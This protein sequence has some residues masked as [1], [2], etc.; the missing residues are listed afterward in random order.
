MWPFSHP[1]AQFSLP[2]DLLYN[3]ERWADDIPITEIAIMSD[4][5]FGALIHQNARLGSFAVAAARQ[6]PS[7]S[8]SAS[9]QP[10]A[11]DLLRVR[12]ELRKAFEWSEKQHGSLE[13]FWVWVEDDENLSILQLA[14][15]LVRPH[16]TSIHLAF[17]IPVAK[18]P[19]SLCVRA[20]SDRWIGAEEEHFVDLDGL[21]L[22]PVAPP[23]VPLLDLPLV[24]TGDALAKQ[25]HLRD[26][27][28]QET[29]ALDPAQTQAFHTVFHSSS[30]VL[31]CS[32][33]APSRGT[34]LELAMWCVPLTSPSC[35]SMADVGAFAG[36][37]SGSS[38][39]P[40][41]S[42]S[43]RARPS[44]ARSPSASSRPS[45]APR[46]SPSTSSRATPT[47]TASSRPRPPSASRRRTRS[48]AAS[49]ASPRLSR[50]STSSSR[51]TC[52]RSTRRTSSS[53]RACGGPTRACG[54]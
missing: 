27:Y 51:T 11:H 40:A 31:L 37:R 30:N 18:A 36:A 9:L 28:G 34:L 12:I 33:S 19:K 22:P 45:P 20:I 44:P 24:A 23:H 32:P 29:P 2:P 3:I 35:A 50:A 6:F 10:L 39:R 25:P 21:V 42:S 41:S 13:A 5:D 8:I 52:T 16:S 53:S 17:T 38:P 26:L 46:R 7:L 49:A 47:P 54:S 14:R 15:T 43:R 48:C 1:L 4:A